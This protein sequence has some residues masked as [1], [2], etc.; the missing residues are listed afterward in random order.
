MAL[1]GAAR[2]LPVVI[3]APIAWVLAAGASGEKRDIRPRSKSLQ[4]AG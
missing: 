4:V 3:E 1:A 2:A